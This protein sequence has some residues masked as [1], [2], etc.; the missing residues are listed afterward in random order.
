MAI[1][2]FGYLLAV[3]SAV[4]IAPQAYKIYKTKNTEGVSLHTSILG[5]STML[6]WC[7]YTAHIKDAPAFTSSIF[8]LFLWL[9]IYYQVEKNNSVKINKYIYIPWFFI[10]ILSF[11][12]W[13]T[14]YGFIAGLGSALWS[15]PQA[16][17]ILKVEEYSGV[18]PLAYLALAL[19]NIGWVIYGL[20]VGNNIYLISPVFQMPV[21]F[22]IAYKSYRYR[23]THTLL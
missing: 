17:T 19:E 15:L 2:I 22:F 3:A 13:V 23:K 7:F 10:V 5:V 18:S 14:S 11:T 4:T 1:M 20:G 16:F 9:Y 8:P 12:P 6:F 21:T